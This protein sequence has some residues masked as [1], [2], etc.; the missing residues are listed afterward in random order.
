MEKGTSQTGCA[1]VLMDAAGTLLYH[2]GH[3]HETV[4]EAKQSCQDG[5]FVPSHPKGC[6]IGIWDLE[7]FQP[8]HRPSRQF[9]EGETR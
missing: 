4:R 5:M 7:M 2:C 8:T 9:G 1:M 6:E 3:V